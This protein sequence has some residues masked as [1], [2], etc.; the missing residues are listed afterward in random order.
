MQPTRNF[1][2][3][4]SRFTLAPLFWPGWRIHAGWLSD[5]WRNPWDVHS[6]YRDAKSLCNGARNAN[7]RRQN[8]T[9]H[10]LLL[11]NEVM[12]LIPETRAGYRCVSLPKL[13]LRELLMYARKGWYILVIFDFFIAW[14][15]YLYDWYL[16]IN[17]LRSLFIVVYW[18][19]QLIVQW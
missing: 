11:A 19:T 18:G 17:R 4:F 10:P 12:T 7:D 16:F 15:D 5:P 2:S 8:R 3:G 9:R 13:I 1:I 6:I 14:Y